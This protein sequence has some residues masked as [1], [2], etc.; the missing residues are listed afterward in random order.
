MGITTFYIKLLE[1]PGF[2]SPQLHQVFLFNIFTGAE[3][4][5]DPSVCIKRC[6]EDEIGLAKKSLTYKWQFSSRIREES[7]RNRIRPSRRS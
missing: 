1:A 4:E 2:E 6:P 3:M 7:R 5:I